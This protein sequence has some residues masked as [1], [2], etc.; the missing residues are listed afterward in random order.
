MCYPL[1]DKNNKI[2]DIIYHEDSISKD[3]LDNAFFILAGEKAKGMPLTKTIPK[4]LAKVDGKPILKI[5]LEI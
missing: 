5:L 1:I 2:I 4:P 3:I